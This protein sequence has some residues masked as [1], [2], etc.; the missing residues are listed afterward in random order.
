MFYE[1]KSKKS[2]FSTLQCKDSELLKVLKRFSALG[3]VINYCL[4]R[5]YKTRVASAENS[6]STFKLLCIMHLCQNSVQVLK[7]PNVSINLKGM[8]Q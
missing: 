1:K 4:V 6:F 3:Q 2:G 5:I 7:I 8:N